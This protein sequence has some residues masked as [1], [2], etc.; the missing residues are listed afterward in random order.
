MTPAPNT[1][2]DSGSVSQAKTSSLTT[3]RSRTR[4]NIGG[5]NGDEPVAMTTALARHARAVDVELARARRSARGR[6]AGASAGISSTPSS[7]EPD[8][9]VALAP[10]AVHDRARRRPRPSACTP[11]GPACRAWC[12]ASA[13][14]MSSLLGMQPTRAHVVPYAPASIRSDLLRR[15][16][17]AAR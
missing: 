14:A 7:D 3:R 8:E 5:T 1:A 4:S 2:T 10:D 11:N 15:R 16:F 13:A 9:A 17:A 12:A 6:A